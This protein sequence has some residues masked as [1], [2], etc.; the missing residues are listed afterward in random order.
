MCGIVGLYQ[1]DSPPNPALLRE[2]N[3]TL[4]HRGPDGEGAFAAGPVALA[5]RR[6]AIIDLVTGDQPLF[7]EDETVA[8]VF[9]GE[10]YNYQ[11]LRAELIR[12]GHRFATQADTE[13]L[14]H[15]YEAW[16]D[17]LPRH[18]NGMFAFALW[19]GRQQRLLLAR[20]QL[21]IKPLYYAELAGGGLAFASELKALEPVRSWSRELDPLALDWYLATRYVPAPR[22]IYRGARKLPAAHCLTVGLN[23]PL[24]ARRYWDVAFEPG[25]ARTE[26]AWLAGLRERLERAVRRQMVADVPLGAF[27]S[28]GVDSSIVVGLMA[29]AAQ[30]P[31]RTFAVT[32]PGWPGL[33]ESGFARQAAGRF[34]SLH[35]EISVEANVAGD[36]PALARHLDEPFADPATLP[37]WLMAR[38]TRRHVTVVLTGEGADELFAGYGWYG[39]PRPWP[40]PVAWRAPLRRLARRLLAGRR[41]RHTATARLA[42]NFAAFYAESILSSVTQAEE[43]A[44]LYRPAWLARLEAPQPAPL[45]DLAGR[46]AATAGRPWQS[47]MQELDLTVWLEGDPLVKA[48]R[49]TMLASLEARVPFL[50]VDVVEW[51]AQVPPGFHRQDGV[52]KALLRRA[53]ADLLPEAIFRR[54]KHAFDVPIAAWLRGPLRAPLAAALADDSPLWSVLRPEPVRKMAQAHWAGR[55][56]FGRELWTLLH[57]AAW[58]QPRRLTIPEG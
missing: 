38:E 3:A 20:D 36:W 2:M 12:Q 41:G 7:N 13:V 23:E 10:I 35:T 28:G 8:V 52:S 34:N 46:F 29:Q 55:Q 58:W 33:D 21:G 16:G 45:A 27:L 44:Q 56:D 14:V 17:D 48:D 30:E 26:E 50:D 18:L 9:N 15:G 40:I 47:R 39:W 51:V 32:F 37:T 53:F 5:M 54:P 24:R 6:L 57:L 4:G 31:V 49:A 19:D 11:E 1:P 22:S 43:R 42:P 25:P